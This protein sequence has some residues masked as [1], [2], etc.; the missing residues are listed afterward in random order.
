MKKLD[1]PDRITV[2]ITNDCNLACT[3]C[4]HQKIKMDIGYMEE[5]LYKRIVDEMADHLPIKMV[6]FF[7]GEPLLHP[8]FVSFMKY[9]KDKGIGPI[10]L[11]SN[12]M[13]LDDE[14]G[15]GIIDAGVD[16]IS[17]SIDTINPEIYS[18][19][20]VRGD[21][22]VTN[23]NVES[24]CNKCKERRNKGLFAPTVQVSTINI[25]DYREER[26]EFVNKWLEFADIVRVYEEHDE[27]GRLV[28]PEVQKQLNVF[29]ER[30]PCRKIFTDMLIYWNGQFSMC[31]Y[32]WDEKTVFGDANTMSLK[33]VWD[34]DAYEEVRRMHLENRIENCLCTDCHH[35]K[36]DYS[37]NGYIGTKYTRD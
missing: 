15:E 31:N 26:E 8:K 21:L 22:K 24:F 4:N 11:T 16:F 32:D 33:E 18:C 13:L 34:G 35:W 3:F 20:R 36:I 10:Q 7:R 1:F 19:S 5:S 17:F 25:K 14:M 23:A 27:K 30:M 9:A 29:E 28:D 2:E 12:G 37:E 6:P